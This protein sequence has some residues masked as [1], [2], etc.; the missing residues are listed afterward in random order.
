MVAICP[1]YALLRDVVNASKHR[2]LTRGGE[3]IVSADSIREL[4]VVTTYQDEQGEYRNAAKS[5]EITLIDGTTRAISPDGKKY[6]GT[7]ELNQDEKNEFYLITD[8]EKKQEFMRK[9]MRRRGELVLHSENP[10][11]AGPDTLV[12]RFGPP[13]E[14]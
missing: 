9:V 5:I 10:G 12:A 3:Q 8:E 6:V 13:L 4:L 1:D 11:L 14:P 7:V 2:H